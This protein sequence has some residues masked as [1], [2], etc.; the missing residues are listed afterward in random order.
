MSYPRGMQKTDASAG[1]M[2]LGSHGKYDHEFFDV[3]RAVADAARDGLA[4][5]ARYG[6]GGTDVGAARAK[7]LSSGSPRVTLRDIVYIRSYFRRHAVDNLHQ[8]NPPSNG[9]IAWQL[10]GG[11]AGREWAEKLYERH[12]EKKPARNARKGR[13]APWDDEDLIEPS[14]LAL[15]SRTAVTESAKWI[16]AGTVGGALV[17]SILVLS[18]R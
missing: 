8:R 15:P 11:Y 16:A 9:W 6:R 2:P 5:R 7:Q 10:W 4:L 18:R 14:G 3:P 1:A 13:S 12:V 17:A